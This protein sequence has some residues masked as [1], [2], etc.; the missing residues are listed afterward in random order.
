MN[1]FRWIAPALAVLVAAAGCHGS[2]G[3]IHL[4]VTFA[5]GGDPGAVAA[6][7]AEVDSR[8]STF[9]L[10]R[11]TSGWSGLVTDVPAGRRTV[12]VKAVGAGGALLFEGQ[13]SALVRGGATA[14]LMVALRPVGASGG[15]APIIQSLTA[16]A[17]TVA[18][19]QVIQLDAAATDPDAEDVPRL[20]FAW[21]ASLGKLEGDS[22]GLSVRW[23]APKGPPALVAE[24]A[25]TV[26]DPKGLSATAS[27]FVGVEV[28]P[29]STDVIAEVNTWPRVSIRAGASVSA[30]GGVVDLDADA[31]D[32]D[33]DPLAYS[34]SAVGCSG[35]FLAPT[36]R[37]STSFQFRAVEP[38]RPC[39][40]MVRVADGRG[41]ADSAV[42]AVGAGPAGSARLPLIEQA[43]EPDPSFTGAPVPLAIMARDPSGGPLSFEWTAQNGE[44]GPV[45]STGGLSVTTFASSPCSGDAFA[46]VRIRG[47]AG[48][49]VIVYQFS[50]SNCPRSCNELKQRV[51]AAADGIYPIAARAEQPIRVFCD[52][53]TDG[54]GWT[55]VG[56]HDGA[57]ASARLFDQAIGT[58]D[59]LRARGPSYALG[60]LPQL[61]DGEMMVALDDPDPA[62]AAA[63]GALVAFRYPPEHPNF[64]RGPGP[65]YSGLPFEYRAQVS[66]AYAPST[67][68]DCAGAGWGA[69]N[70]RGQ[71]LLQFGGPGVFLGAGL[72]GREGWGHEA[73][74]YV[75]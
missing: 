53:T 11:N 41:G 30:N 34:W 19:G 24:I 40:L 1:G 37:S 49:G 54:G 27:L 8:P 9:G 31:N 63:A 45:Q 66:S 18:F 50:I 5:P 6:V 59:R 22:A 14:L 13:G 7:A 65:C 73:Y 3:A 48:V 39:A 58:Y 51:P 47:G 71:W 61:S 64:N 26:T 36:G 2:N 12:S 42:V 29:V 52:M 25:F 21:A 70:E 44:L 17:S 35:T 68:W 75:R 38:A 20:S 74:V 62:R 55:F 56:H 69:R 23:R 4:S 28:L 60:I 10:A 72:G 33:G 57:A 32:A 67:G 15:H 16:E 43:I 46:T